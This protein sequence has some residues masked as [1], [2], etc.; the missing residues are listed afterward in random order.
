MNLEAWPST[1]RFPIDVD[2]NLAK[3]SQNPI[4][5][6]PD[7][8]FEVSTFDTVFKSQVIV[9]LILLGVFGKGGMLEGVQ[10]LGQRLGQRPIAVPRTYQY[11]RRR[12]CF[13][14]LLSH[15]CWPSLAVLIE[16]EQA[17]ALLCGTDSIT[18][19][20]ASIPLPSP[21]S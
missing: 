4:P 7:I 21:R 19:Q 13:S 17:L 20:L 15:W 18:G 11:V 10:M 3:G 5:T 14:S 2:G 6:Y 8:C 9:L 16:C 1:S 12:V